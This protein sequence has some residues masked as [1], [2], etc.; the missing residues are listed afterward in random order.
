MTLFDN[1]G[2]VEWLDWH[3]HLDVVALCLGML[4]GYFYAI[5]DLRPQIS[6][7]GRV[8]RSQV[9]SYCAGVLVIYIA[10]G[11]PMHDLSEQYLLSVHMTQHL[12]FTLVAPPLLIVGIPVWLWQALLRDKLVMRVAKV[13]TNPLVAFGVFN[14]MIVLTHLPEVVDYSLTHHWFHFFVHVALFGSAMMM[15]WPIL[16]Q[17]PELPQL[18]EPYQMAYLFVQSVLPAVIGGFIVFSRTPV[19]EFYAAAP[20]IWGISAVE[21]QQIAAGL[22]KTITPVI[23]WSF[24]ALAFFRWYAREQAEDKGP[25]WREVEE[26]LQEMGLSGRQ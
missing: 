2:G 5:N 7:A 22:M 1:I 18:A 15:W 11:S 25:S 6:D 13:L 4:A 12:L 20:R 24:I 19:Y 9:I 3:L 14:S 17:V 23:L 8:K 26:E 10:A 21:D 16:S